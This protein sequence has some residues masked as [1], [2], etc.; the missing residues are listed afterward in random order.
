M[1][2]PSRATGRRVGTRRAIRPLVN[3]AAAISAAAVSLP[4]I[5]AQASARPTEP[6]SSTGAIAKASVVTAITKNPQSR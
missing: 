2:A 4:P 1:N 5:R 6:P 3:G